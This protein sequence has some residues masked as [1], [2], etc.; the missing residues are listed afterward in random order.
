VYVA[1]ISIA[2]PNVRNPNKIEQPRE[3]TEIHHA[4]FLLEIPI[5][6]INIKAKYVIDAIGKFKQKVT[7]R[8]N[9]K[10]SET[11]G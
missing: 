5:F 3:I 6:A 8:P 4:L 7:K 1:F 9:I 2:I 11:C 10:N